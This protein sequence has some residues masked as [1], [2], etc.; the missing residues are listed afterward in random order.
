MDGWIDLAMPW[1]QFVLRATVAYLGLLLLMRLA[2]KHA[3]AELS[4]FEI[5][6]LISVGGTLRT[7]MLGEDRSLLGP[8][9]CIVTML[10]LD[11]LIA[12]AAARSKRFNDL[13]TGRAVLIAERG[14][15]DY[16]ALLRHSVA[17]DDFER[18]M[19]ERGIASIAQVEQAR[20]EPNG[21]I[22]FLSR[23]EE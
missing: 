16:R 15:V 8:F 20:L 9:I 13:V 5:L 1:W 17:P 14:R 23:H 10:L 18:A 19:R 4:P 22:T 21:K 11:K 7:A 6:V 12:W 2:G 3:F